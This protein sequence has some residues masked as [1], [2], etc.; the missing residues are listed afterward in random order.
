MSSNVVN[1]QTIREKLGTLLDAAFDSTWDV[2]NYGES[3]FN[4]KARNIT[5]SSGDTIYPNAGAED[6]TNSDTAAEMVMFIS[7][8][9]LYEKQEEGWT[10][11]L[12]N[13]AMD[14][15]RKTI[16][17]MLRDHYE[18][19]GFW[20]SV[21][22]SGKSRPVILTDVGGVPYRFEAIPIRITI[23]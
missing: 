22:E 14:L 6:Q 20:V 3:T 17:D 4:G 8:F 18:E 16:A 19:S 12:S 15:A 1:R 13:N 21:E 2:F 9:I 11:L 10:P 23:Y 5:V 7:T